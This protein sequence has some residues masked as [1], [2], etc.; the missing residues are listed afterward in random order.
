MTSFVFFIF[1]L[2]LFI[3]VITVLFI[4]SILKGKNQNQ[5]YD[6]PDLDDFI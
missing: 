1:L 6:L 5:N 2:I 3:V 4:R